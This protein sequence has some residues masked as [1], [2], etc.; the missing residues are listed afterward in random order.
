MRDVKRIQ[1][2]L[3]D[4]GNVWEQ[5]FPDMRFMQ[6]IVNFQSWL[7]SDGFY[8]EDDQLIEK[9]CKFATEI[10][11]PKIIHKTADGKTYM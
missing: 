10:Y 1:P 6:V 4:I 7:G 11:A 5:C 8:I 3:T 2:L 9:F